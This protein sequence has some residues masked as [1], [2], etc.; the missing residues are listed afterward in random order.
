MEEKRGG[1]TI[2]GFTEEQTWVIE[3]VVEM[4]VSRGVEEGMKAYRQDHCASHEERTYSLEAALFGRTELGLI[5]LDDRLRAAETTLD[6]LRRITWLAIG[7]ML[8]SIAALTVAVFELS[9][10][11]G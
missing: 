11:S 1:P 10:F 5:G 4:A 6:T 3:K 9:F 7:A 2:P 8:T